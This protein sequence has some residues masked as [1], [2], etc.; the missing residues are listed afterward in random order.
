M[1]F[2]RLILMINLAALAAMF[3]PAMANAAQTY[4]LVIGINQYPHIVSLDG[5][6][7]D[8]NDIA[9]TLTGSGAAEVIELTDAEADKATIQASFEK[10][11]AK[12]AVGDTIVFSFAGHGAQITEYVAGDEAD[13]LDEL[14]ILPGFD[15]EKMNETMG[16]T[17]VDNE[18][19]AWFE[20][21]RRRNVNILFVA[22]SCHSGGMT[23]N[24][25][26]KLRFVAIDPDAKPQ[27]VSAEILKGGRIADSG[28]DNVTM[29]A[30]AKEGAPIPEVVI[31][32]KPR[33][34][35][36]FSVARALEGHADRNGDG[37]LSRIELE[38]YVLQTVKARSDALQVPVF[39]PLLPRTT[40][41]ALVELTPVQTAMR[42]I[43]AQKANREETHYRLVAE[44][45]WKPVL[46]VE[47]RG[48]SFRPE[49]TAR[50]A[51][52]YLWNAAVREFRTPNG[53]LAAEKVSKFTVNDV[54]SKF[55]L[56]D[57]LNKMAVQNPGKLVLTP[58]KQLYLA[59]ERV[60]FDTYAGPYRN[61]LVFN[62]ANTGEAQFLDMAIDGHKT[63][64]SWL[65]EMKIVEP[66]GADHL[67]VI[68]T[69]QPVDAIGAATKRGIAPADLINLIKSRLDGTDSSVAVQ[70]LFSRARK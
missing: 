12:S 18:L 24:V 57:L 33:G 60:K 66:F 40:D 54:V 58:E 47:V 29:L 51:R 14:F 50:G 19:N 5:A 11:L 49:N 44:M 21:A 53:E 34:A 38:D 22:D 27:M 32:E 59:G 36:S 67:V 30:A 25:L 46:P 62:L 37:S 1:Q 69:N 42:A 3:A 68:A 6:V 16:E 70:P 48:T 35:L 9:R 23:R 20:Q 64:K 15:P 13:G 63:E 41:E 45:G 7:N 55:I 2:I 26:G 43:M 61:L 8:A 4:G 10:L 28:L 56:L 52:P 65:S 31:D 39:Y 17:I